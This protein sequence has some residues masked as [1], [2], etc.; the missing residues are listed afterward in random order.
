MVRGAVFGRTPSCEYIS[1]DQGTLPPAFLAWELEL[2]KYKQGGKGCI[3]PS[4]CPHLPSIVGLI[5]TSHI[6]LWSLSLVSL[7]TL[8]SLSLVSLALVSLWSLSLSLWSLWLWSLSGL[9]HSLS[10]LSGLSGSGLSLVSISHWSI[11]GLSLVSLLSLSDLS[12]ALSLTH[13]N[14]MSVC[15]NAHSRLKSQHTCSHMFWL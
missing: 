12:L 7:V 3:I 10:G 9:S 15:H 8:W 4:H 11:S 13:K 5:S 2:S 6:S 14:C 1:R